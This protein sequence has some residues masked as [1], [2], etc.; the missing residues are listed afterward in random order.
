MFLPNIMP[1]KHAEEEED[2]YLELWA[3][4]SFSMAILKTGNGRQYQIQYI[5]I[6]NM[7]LVIHQHSDIIQI[8]TGEIVYTI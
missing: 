7:I 8:V 5:Y 6:R 1:P 4:Q 2:L 3:Y